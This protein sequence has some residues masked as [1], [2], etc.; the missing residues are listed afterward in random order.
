MSTTTASQG[1]FPDIDRRLVKKN[2][3]QELRRSIWRYRMLYPLLIPGIIYFGVFSY[4]PLYAIQL[5][6][7]KF[8]IGKGITGSSWVGFDN[9]TVLFARTEFWDAVNNT[10]VI[11]L[12][13]TAIYFPIPI[14]LA[15]MINEITSKKLA[16]SLQVVFTLPHFLSW[17]TVC[18]IILNLLADNGAI[19]S[20]IA[21]LGNEKVAFLSNGHIFRFLLVFSEIWKESG[22][23]A[24]I[25]MAAIAGIDQ[26]MYESAT[27]DGANRL[28]KAWF[29]T[30]PSIK[31]TAAIL[32]LLSLGS[33]MNGNF[34]QIFNMYNPTVYKT[35]EIIDTYI[36]N[37]TFLQ[38][39]NY[40]LSTAVGLFKGIINCILMVVANYAVGKLS[41]ESKIL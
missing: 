6:F 26:S 28:Q 18:G 5:A 20:L 14:I 13:K 40:G 12:L 37:I 33:V 24:I 21:S 15:I 2:K 23:T 4:A 16:R 35:A 31:S 17:I 8:S 36:Y 27:V 34:D 41:S 30:V 22:W 7:K 9:F 10:I 25:Y 1:N 38:S 29:I 3:K 39:A 19:N 32:L 11:S